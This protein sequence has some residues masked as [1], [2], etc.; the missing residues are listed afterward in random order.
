M[1]PFHQYGRDV[2]HSRFE[3]L[4]SALTCANLTNYPSP[5]TGAYAWVKCAE[6]TDCAKFFEN[7][8]LIAASGENF[9][10]TSQ[11]E[12]GLNWSHSEVPYG[13]I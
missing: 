11:C 13:P 7:V 2:M 10:G 4:N 1:L 12:F 8:S 6:G 9:G 3:Q 5:T